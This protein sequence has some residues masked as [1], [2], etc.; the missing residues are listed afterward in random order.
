MNDHIHVHIEA[1]PLVAQRAVGFVTDER[2]GGIAVFVGTTRRF[3]GDKETSELYYEAYEEMALSEM[4]KLAQRAVE[5]FGLSKAYL[6][7][8]VGE[9]AFGEASVLIAVSS[10]HRDEAFNAC[11]W[12]IDWVKSE[13]PIWKKERYTNGEE[14]WVEGNL[15]T[16]D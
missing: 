6:A 10:P 11:R 7:H 3:T 14:E 12:L 1:A 9:V 2:A 8:R 15:P 16:S 13:V 5:S 4:R